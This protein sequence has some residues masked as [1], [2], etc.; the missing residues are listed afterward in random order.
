MFGVV[1]FFY[2]KLDPLENEDYFSDV[3]RVGFV[4]S[5]LNVKTSR[6]FVD[7]TLSRTTSLQFFLIHNGT[8]YCA[9]C[10]RVLCWEGSPVVRN[11]LLSLQG[12]RVWSLVREL[13]SHK[14]HSRAGGE[15]KAVHTWC[16]WI[17]AWPSWVTCY[18]HFLNGKAEA[19]RNLSWYKPSKLVIKLGLWTGAISI[20]PMP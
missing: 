2:L 17:F 12:A 11:F 19:L 8:V 13:R 9:V 3:A 10:S 4:S 1:I 7:C 5:L 14:P 20:L 16:H 18:H 6:S 15:K